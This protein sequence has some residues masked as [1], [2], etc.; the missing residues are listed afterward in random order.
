MTRLTG[1]ALILLGAG[2]G[3]LGSTINPFA[4][5]IASG[6]AGSSIVEGIVGRIVILVVG[7]AIGIWWVMRY[8]ARVQA[9][10]SSSLVA[11]DSAESDAALPRARAAD[12]GRARRR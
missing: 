7:T 6:F 8:A 4:T 1:A 3:V 5:G 10:P 2:I 12:V 9:D 11:A